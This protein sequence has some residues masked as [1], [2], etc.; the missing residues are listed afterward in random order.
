MKGEDLSS[1]YSSINDA[2]TN[3]RTSEIDEPTPLERAAEARR[4]AEEAARFAKEQVNR[5]MEEK[6]STLNGSE[7]V[8]E[9]RLKAWEESRRK[10]AEGAKQQARTFY[11][12]SG[13]Y[14]GAVA[15]TWESR[16][17]YLKSLKNSAEYM[18]SIKDSP[19]A[20]N[21]EWDPITGNPIIPEDQKDEGTAKIDPLA[22]WEDSATDIL[23][24]SIIYHSKG[25]FF[26]YAGSLF[27]FPDC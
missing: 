18:N 13:S 10:D 23:N 20:A 4:K 6:E 22:S 19:E 21:I 5:L 14:M 25:K 12:N 26:K 17:E 7:D 3:K 9:E 11:P 8:Q 2:E 15:K 16:S 24:V 1:L 27:V